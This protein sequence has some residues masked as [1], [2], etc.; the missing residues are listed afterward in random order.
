MLR[1]SLAQQALRE[2]GGLKDRQVCK[3][4]RAF[5]VPTGHPALKGSMEGRA[6]KGIK[7]PLARMGSK[8]LPDRTA[9]RERLPT[10]FRS[11]PATLLTPTMKTTQPDM[12]MGAPV[13]ASIYA[14]RLIANERELH[15]KGSS[16][17]IRPAR[18]SGSARCS[19][20]SRSIGNF[21][22]AG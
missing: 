14:V 12:R 3:G 2:C 22:R 9:N 16:G 11:V 7:D 20:R 8:D 10:D 5:R 1:D 4:L 18:H 19:R 21:R 6:P 17:G 13:P 15:N